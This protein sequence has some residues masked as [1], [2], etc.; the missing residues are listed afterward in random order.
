MWGA[1]SKPRVG[2]VNGPFMALHFVHSQFVG[3]GRE[4]G[5][6]CVNLK[7]DMMLYKEALVHF[8]LLRT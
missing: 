4:V 1:Q 8:Q 2:V 5:S 3:A 7:N 6:M